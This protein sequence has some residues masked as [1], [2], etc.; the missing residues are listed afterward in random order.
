MI[1]RGGRRITGVIGQ[2]RGI[3]GW[4]LLLCIC[5]LQSKCFIKREMIHRLTLVVF[6]LLLP[7]HRTC[8]Q[9]RL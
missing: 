3:T 6:F 8:S 5:I 7:F 1:L 2:M 4:C 9:R